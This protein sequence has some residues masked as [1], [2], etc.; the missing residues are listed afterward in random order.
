MIMEIDLIKYLAMSLS[1]V[2]ILWILFFLYGKY[3]KKKKQEREEK[4]NNTL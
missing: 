2:L 3:R 1:P 4:E